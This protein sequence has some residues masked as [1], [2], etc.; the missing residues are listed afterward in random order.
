LAILHDITPIKNIERDLAFARDQ[1]IYANQTKSQILDNVSFDLRSPLN[2]ILGYVELLR[3]G[4]GGEPTP[5][6]MGTLDR[7]LHNVNQMTFFVEDLLDQ[8]AIEK[9]KISLNETVFSVSELA[10]LAQASVEAS[11]IRKGLALSFQ[12]DPELPERM[13]GDPHRL[14]QILCNLANNAIR[15]TGEGWVTVRLFCQGPEEWG[16]Q[17]SD[18]GV[19][20]PAQAREMIYE[21]FWQVDG[22]PTRKYGGAGLG[23]SIVKY[24]VAI[25][26]GRIELVSELGRGSIFTIYLP[27][28]R[29]VGEAE[30]DGGLS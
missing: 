12:L 1:A 20:I 9:G 30:P 14:Q 27:L 15:Y 24:L 25:M 26:E 18:T 5:Q 11:A 4:L 19:G 7:V 29:P 17:V 28:R 2:T 23:L 8:A 22:S 21:P 6:Q 3:Q 16:I 10:A 13:L